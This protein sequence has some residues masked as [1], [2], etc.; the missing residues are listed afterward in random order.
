MN[1]SAQWKAFR[2]DLMHFLTRHPRFSLVFR[3]L[4]A[5]AFFTICDWVF[6]LHADWPF[7][8]HIGESVGRSVFTTLLSYVFTR[9][10]RKPRLPSTPSA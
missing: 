5:F 9:A 10:M 4:H 6:S 2:E 8:S 7:R 1:I 3:F